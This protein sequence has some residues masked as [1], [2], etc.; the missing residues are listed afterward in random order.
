MTSLYHRFSNISFYIRFIH[1]LK[2]HLCRLDIRMVDIHS[3]SWSQRLHCKTNSVYVWRA[4][5][6]ASPRHS[7]FYM[8][9]C[10]SFRII[11]PIRS[12]GF[13]LGIERIFRGSDFEVRLPRTAS[14]D[15]GWETRKGWRMGWAKAKTSTASITAKRN[16]YSARLR[17]ALTN[18]SFDD[19]CVVNKMCCT[20]QK[21]FC[22][23]HFCNMFFFFFFRA[24]N[25]NFINITWVVKIEK[26]KKKNQQNFTP[27]NQIITIWIDR[28]IIESVIGLARINI[29]FFS[30]WND[31]TT[32]TDMSLIERPPSRCKRKA[33]SSQSTYLGS[34]R[35]TF[36][37]QEFAIEIILVE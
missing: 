33:N 15:R 3:K 6:I 7:D 34:P 1:L 30:R 9:C 12:V 32:I 5:E 2:W 18:R 31:K 37:E 27:L 4:C 19:A 26:K 28:V 21:L 23:I 11:L 17:A 16:L 13:V 20:P 8:P 36:I 29:W 35:S 22:K 24:E 14:T 25:K 10:Q